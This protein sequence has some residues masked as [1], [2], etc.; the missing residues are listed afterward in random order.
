MD[1]TSLMGHIIYYLLFQMAW[2]RIPSFGWKTGNK[3]TCANRAD[4]MDQPMYLF[5]TFC[6]RWV[7]LRRTLFVY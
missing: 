6:C 3:N 4:S 7:G 5:L 2:R 1:G